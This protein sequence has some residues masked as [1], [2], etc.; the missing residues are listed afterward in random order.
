MD[1]AAR[2]VDVRLMTNSKRNMCML[3]IGG[4][5]LYYIT[6]AD[7]EDMITGGIRIFEYSGSA[8]MH[9]KGFIVDDVVAAVGS[10]N[11]TFTAEKYYTESGFAIYDTD[12]IQEVRR[13][14][15]NDFTQCKEVTLESLRREPSEPIVT[16]VV[17]VG[18][19]R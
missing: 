8:P 11:A 12:G 2:G 9:A 3:P 4:W 19:S 5:P 1:A 7:Y 10:Y 14:F 6:Q 17:Q 13:M 15:E 16:G 18:S